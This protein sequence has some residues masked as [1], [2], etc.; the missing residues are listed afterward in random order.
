MRLGPRPK[1]TRAEPWHPEAWEP[2]NDLQCA[3]CGGPMRLL[4]LVDNATEKQIGQF[5]GCKQYPACYCTHSAHADG[6]PM[7]KPANAETRAKRHEAHG[8]FDKLWKGDGWMTRAAAYRWLAEQFGAD[9]VHMGSM[10]LEECERVIRM[11]T[12]KLAALRLERKKI[13][14]RRRKAD[15]FTPKRAGQLADRKHRTERHDRKV[16]R[17][18]RSVPPPAAP[19]PEPEEEPPRSW[20]GR[21]NA[22]EVLATH[23]AGAIVLAEGVRLDDT[24]DLLEFEDEERHAR[25]QL[26][27]AS[28]GR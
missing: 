1:K 22:L 21:S 4:R 9:E 13:E 23:E 16:E 26:W 28:R 11:S 15:K 12:H 8:V 27:I 7:G 25:R 3:E 10:D 14:R 6:K 2:P 17:R 19:K 18:Q 5:Y 24:D 20:W